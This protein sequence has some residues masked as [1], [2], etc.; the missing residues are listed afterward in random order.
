MAQRDND[1]TSISGK[2]Q[3]KRRKTSERE[4]LNET[5]ITEV[6]DYQTQKENFMRHILGNNN[7]SVSV[8]DHLDRGTK[9]YR[10]VF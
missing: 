3:A 7:K 2:F 1:K 8:Y 5:I 6:Y 4:I 10:M 9:E